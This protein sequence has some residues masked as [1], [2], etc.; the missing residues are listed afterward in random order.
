MLNVKMKLLPG[1]LDIGTELI[2]SQ[3]VDI[4]FESIPLS[5]TGVKL[6]IA[7]WKLSASVVPGTISF[8][9]DANSMNM[10]LFE[11]SFARLGRGVGAKVGVVDGDVIVGVL[12]FDGIIVGLLEDDGEAVVGVEE[13][14]SITGAAVGVGFVE[15]FVGSVE[16]EGVV[17]GPSVFSSIIIMVESETLKPKY[18]LRIDVY[19]S[20]FSSIHVFKAES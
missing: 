12:D 20:G 18:I 8:S 1:E 11:D 3:S 16:G 9:I 2:S 19:T 10:D 17:V 6:S 13:G 5:S 15:F 4:L 7:S 14:M